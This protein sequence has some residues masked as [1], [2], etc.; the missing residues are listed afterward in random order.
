M[1]PSSCV[2]NQIPNP[3]P[4]IPRTLHH[5]IY[6][7]WFITTVYTTTTQVFHLRLQDFQGILSMNWLFS[8]EIQLLLGFEWRRVFITTAKAQ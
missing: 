5:I 6:L 1:L 8:Y 2:M 7:P 4:W 3:C